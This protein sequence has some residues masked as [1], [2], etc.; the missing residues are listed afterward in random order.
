MNVLPPGTLL[1]LMYLEERL[2][3]I[4]PGRFLE[5][6]PG[7]GEI[8]NLLLNLGWSGV[9][10]DLELRTVD[11]LKVRFWKEFEEGRYEPIN[12]DY[13]AEISNTSIKF[14]LIISCMVIE[15]LDSELEKKFMQTS[16]NLLSEGG[17]MIGLVPGS[18]AHWG[19]E[20]E[21]AG[22]CRRYSREALLALATHNKW[23]VRHV[24]GLTYPISNILLPISNFI[25]RRAE[26]SKLKMS[27]IDKTKASGIRSV[28][29]KTTFPSILSLVLN[30]Y[31]LY[32]LHWVQKAF[33]YSSH[34]LVLYFE[35]IPQGRN[36][37]EA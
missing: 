28:K 33:S 7:R 12:E 20:D 14:D 32:P 27:D 26:S 25:V 15:H 5:I 37:G 18:P 23:E 29:F 19:I 4:P 2:R 34:S 21:I 9:S 35:A 11:S 30:K 3:E 36:K 31:V 8:S 13:L 10:Y 1:Q 22:H 6:G 17:L 16:H 24:A